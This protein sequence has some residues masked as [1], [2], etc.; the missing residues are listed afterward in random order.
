[1]K[2]F[3]TNKL[4]SSGPSG[5]H[6]EA[7]VVLSLLHLVSLMMCVTLLLTRHWEHCEGIG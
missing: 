6:P 3:C 5:W 1:M 4:G 2:H 7:G